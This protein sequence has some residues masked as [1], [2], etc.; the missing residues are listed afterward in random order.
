MPVH[1]HARVPHDMHEQIRLLAQQMREQLGGR[2]EHFAAP[3][4]FP[5]RIH[6]AQRLHARRHNHFLM[7]V[8]NSV[9]ISDGVSSKLNIT[10]LTTANSAPS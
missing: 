9:A 7:H 10:S 5:Q 6:R 1:F 3:H 4:R 8:H 2:A